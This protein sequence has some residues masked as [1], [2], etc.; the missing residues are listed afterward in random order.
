MLKLPSKITS[1]S[2]N[3][4][5]EVLGSENLDYFFREFSST[6]PYILILGDFEVYCDHDTN[7]SHP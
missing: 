1:K 6:R 4:K 5:I 7:I 3:I 2:P